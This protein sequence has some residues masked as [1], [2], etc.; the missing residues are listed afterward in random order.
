MYQVTTDQTD[1]RQPPAVV[2]PPPTPPPMPNFDYDHLLSKHIYSIFFHFF[3]FC[4][5]IIFFH[6]R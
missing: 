2:K 6:E 5:R 4:F 3:T 1:G